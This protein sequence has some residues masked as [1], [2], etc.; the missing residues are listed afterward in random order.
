MVGGKDSRGDS[1]GRI[2]CTL[3]SSAFLS[4]KTCGVAPIYG[5][6][7]GSLFYGRCLSS[8]GVFTVEKTSSKAIH[9]TYPFRQLH[10]PVRPNHSRLACR[11][12]VDGTG[13]VLGIGRPAPYWLVLTTHV[14]RL[15]FPPRPFSFRPPTPSICETHTHPE[16]D[17]L[18]LSAVF[19]DTDCRTKRTLGTSLSVEVPLIG[20]HPSRQFISHVS[21]N[22]DLMQ[23]YQLAWRTSVCRLRSGVL[24][25]A[26]PVFPA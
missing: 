6:V 18:L 5:L 25:P 16:A 21:S 12:L 24:E 23:P 9:A 2:K 1:G 20:H 11:K 17:P 13:A 10:R 19:L 15:T 7:Q 3:L 4:S 8:E 14:V 26:F 22:M